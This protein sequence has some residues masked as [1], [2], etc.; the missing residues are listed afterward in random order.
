M[1]MS[2]LLKIETRGSVPVVDPIS[3]DG[4]EVSGLS[5]SKYT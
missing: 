1:K 2:E 3:N 4:L 5:L